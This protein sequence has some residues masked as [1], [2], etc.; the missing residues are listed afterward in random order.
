MP[1]VVAARR[2]I[3]RRLAYTVGAEQG[4]WNQADLLQF[5]RR[6]PDSVIRLRAAERIGP[7]VADRVRA[8]RVG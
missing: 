5:A 4:R 2:P 3:A 1:P 8:M 7:E 6:D